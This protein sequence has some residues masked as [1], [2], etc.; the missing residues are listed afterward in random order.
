VIRTGVN[1]LLNPMLFA[2]TTSAAI[3]AIGF[4]A[5]RRSK[6]PTEI[7]VENEDALL[8]HQVDA[9]GQAIA[10]TF[11]P[12]MD[13][14]FVLWGERLADGQYLPPLMTP[15]LNDV[16]AASARRFESK[17]RWVEEIRSNEPKPAG[18]PAK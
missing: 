5:G 1:L 6:K 11:R 16:L 18:S 10:K 13:P 9:T 8:Q 14:E 17:M 7:Y 12:D 15:T 4:A 3:F 2:F